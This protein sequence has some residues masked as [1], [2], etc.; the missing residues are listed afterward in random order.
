[1]NLTPEQ[2]EIFREQLT[3]RGYL[4]F[5]A[6]IKEASEEGLWDLHTALE[7]GSFDSAEGRTR[8][9]QGAWGNLGG[10]NQLIQPGVRSLRS[11]CVLNSLFHREAG[12][13]RDKLRSTIFIS[14]RAMMK[15]G[16]RVG[17]FCAAWDAGLL[18]PRELLRRL[19]RFI[20]A[21]MVRP[22]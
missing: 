5:D 17:D 7:K 3:A 6:V 11:A 22:A 21:R 16:F 18:D 4:A 19:D 12:R 2:K 10:A 14:N 8:L 9:I 15:H 13:Y 1:M 20:T